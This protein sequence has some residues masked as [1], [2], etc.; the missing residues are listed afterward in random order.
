MSTTKTVH[1]HVGAHKTATTYMQSRLRSNRQR[2]RNDGINFVDLWAKNDEEKRY[3]KQLKRVIEKERVNEQ[4]LALIS[5]QLHD[6]VAKATQPDNSLI[7]LSYENMLGDY[8]L[9]KGPAPYPNAGTAIRHVVNAFPDWQV[10]IFFSIRSLDRFVESGYVQRVFTRYE[11]RRFKGY[12]KQIDVTGLSWMP[13]V[14]AIN[15]AIGAEN[16]FVWEYEKFV[17]A[18]QIVWN[19]LLARPDAEK[20]LVRPAKA[21]NYSLSGKGLRYMRSINKVATPA[22]AR[23][24]RSLIKQTFACQ[25]GYEP[26][27]LLDS[28]M[29]Q[30]LIS[31]YERD[32]AELFGT[33]RES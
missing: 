32:C 11:T 4:K 15:A 2:L 1:F 30:R 10:R 18:E 14:S 13:V 23:K 26:P 27:K 24:F 21:S 25:L 31:S 22:D 17:K 6:I 16:V 9:T 19:A 20:L 7:V 12:M 3:R 8:D 5:T 28:A 29:R 33:R